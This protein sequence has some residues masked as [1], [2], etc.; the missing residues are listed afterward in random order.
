MITNTAVA[1]TRDVE[2]LTVYRAVRVPIAF[3]P[4]RILNTKIITLRETGNSRI[5]IG[6][7]R[8][9]LGLRVT[10]SEGDIPIGAGHVEGYLGDPW[11]AHWVRLR[12]QAFGK[13][14]R[15]KAW[16]DG[17]P[18]PGEWCLTTIT[19]HVE[20]G[21]V[22]LDNSGTS[23]NYSEFGWASISTG[24][25]EVRVPGN[26]IYKGRHADYTDLK[27]LLVSVSMPLVPEVANDPRAHDPAAETY[28]FDDVNI[29]SPAQRDLRARAIETAL[30]VGSPHPP[31][32]DGHGGYSHCSRFAGSVVIPMMDPLFPGD[33]TDVQGA[34]LADPRNGWERIGDGTDR[35]A[36]KLGD[37]WVTRSSGHV[38]IYVGE[39]GGFPDV[40]AD[41]SYGGGGGEDGTRGNSYVARLRRWYIR[42]DGRDVV[43]R[44]YYGYRYVGRPDSPAPII[45][46][47]AFDDRLRAVTTGF[48]LDASHE[49]VPVW[50]NTSSWVTT[51]NGIER[52]T[53]AE[54]GYTGAILKKVDGQHRNVEIVTLA[55]YTDLGAGH[56]IG[57]FARGAGAKGAE[58]FVFLT[59][60]TAAEDASDLSGLRINSK[61]NGNAASDMVFNSQTGVNAP[62]RN[63]VG[64]QYFL[65]L[66]VFEDQVQGKQWKRGTP[67]PEKWDLTMA[68]KSIPAHFQYGGKNEKGWVGLYDGGSA[69]RSVYRFASVAFDGATAP[70]P[71]EY[72]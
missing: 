51:A 69:S 70:I 19:E 40:I 39:Y 20:P 60:Q 5:N 33:L 30:R 67:E 53:P 58:S 29:V 6:L 34:Y 14:I 18:E 57:L 23:D 2:V 28:F 4:R 36:T 64:V 37:V 43:G 9:G 26:M 62:W 1:P 48:H 32:Q 55:H 49:V 22:G 56:K 8:S 65:R 35:S 52:V 50:R 54:T 13:F 38:F 46:D 12:V 7:D 24:G 15:V 44:Y 3:P 66:R 68:N 31:A 10:V 71:R 21:T 17:L 72:L 41:A 63:E 61:T 16:F 25:A 11:T 59:V 47:R 45:P 27:R 42:T